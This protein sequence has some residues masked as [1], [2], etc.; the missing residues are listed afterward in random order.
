M[1]LDLLVLATVATMALK[2]VVGATLGLLAGLVLRR[3]PGRSH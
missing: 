1:T 3:V 2:V